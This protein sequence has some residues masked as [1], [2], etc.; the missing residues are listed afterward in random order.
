MMENDDEDDN[1][2]DWDPDQG[3]ETDD[4]ANE[5]NNDRNNA[6]EHDFSQSYYGFFSD[7]AADDGDG[8]DTQTSN[9]SH[10]KKSSSFAA[11]SSS[12]LFDQYIDDF[13]N[14]SNEY[15]NGHIDSDALQ[16]FYNEASLQR[17]PLS[18]SP[19][20]VF[21]QLSQTS[22]FSAAELSRIEESLLSQSSHHDVEVERQRQKAERKRKR[23]L[24]SIVGRKKR[25]KYHLSEQQI[26]RRLDYCR[27]K[28]EKT[29]D[30][31]KEEDVGGSMEY[32]IRQKLNEPGEQQRLRKI[33]KEREVQRIKRE[34]D[35]QDEL[36]RKR[37][38][39]MWT[40]SSEVDNR[41]NTL[42]E[43][44]DHKEAQA[45]K[46]S[47]LIASKPQPNWNFLDEGYVT[48]PR[49]QAEELP[50]YIFNMLNGSDGQAEGEE[51]T[52]SKT[53]YR[54]RLWLEDITSDA[55]TDK[56]KTA[57][58][59]ASLTKAH[60]KE[61]REEY[62]S[63][64]G[65]TRNLFTA[66]SR[67]FPLYLSELNPKIDL[68]TFS[69][70][71]SCGQ[72][73]MALL[74]G[75]NAKNIWA[76]LVAGGVTFKMLEKYYDNAQDEK[77]NT[78]NE[79][80]PTSDV[81]HSSGSSDS[82]DAFDIYGS[83]DN[84]S[85]YNS[86]TTFGCTSVIGMADSTN[87]DEGVGKGLK[88]NPV[89]RLMSLVHT[90]PKITHR[91][92]FYVKI[93]T[94]LG[95]LR[96]WWEQEFRD[97]LD[98]P[99]TNLGNTKKPSSAELWA[100]KSLFG[101]DGNITPGPFWCS[102]P[103]MMTSPKKLYKRIQAIRLK[104]IPRLRQL[105]RETKRSALPA[106]RNS[107]LPKENQD[108]E[109]AKAMMA[110][111]TNRVEGDTLAK[112]SVNTEVNGTPENT[113][114]K[115]ERCNTDP[116]ERTETS[117][118][119]ED[120]MKSLTCSLLDTI[121]P[122][123]DPGGFDKYAK[124][125][126]EA[127]IDV[128]NIV[129]S[130][131]SF[132][133]ELTESSERIHHLKQIVPLS[134]YQ[135]AEIRLAH[136]NACMWNNTID[137]YL[138]LAET[139]SRPLDL[140]IYKREEKL[141]QCAPLA[142]SVMARQAYI[143]NSGGVLHKRNQRRRLRSWQGNTKE[144]EDCYE[145]GDYYE[146][147][148]FANESLEQKELRAIQISAKDITI[149]GKEYSSIE[150]LSIFTNIHLTTGIAMLAEHLTPLRAEVV[151]RTCSADNTECRTPFDLVRKVLSD[152]DVSNELISSPLDRK[153]RWNARGKVIDDIIVESW[154]NAALLFRQCIEGEP[155]NVDHWT[156]YVATL[157]GIVCVSSGLSVSIF[158]QGSVSVSVKSEVS[159]TESKPKRHQLQFY[160]R[161]RTRASRAMKDFIQITE[162][163]DCPMFHMALSSMLEWTQAIALMHRPT[164]T[165]DTFGLEVTR[166]H[167]FHTYKWA[168]KDCCDDAIARV[169]SLYEKDHIPLN[170]LLD[171]LARA[172]ES[173]PCN[174]VHWYRLVH[175]L[176]A[177]TTVPVVKVCSPQGN[178]GETWCQKY[179]SEWEGN[180]FHSPPHSTLM[181]KPDF[182]TMVLD[183][184]DLDFF[185]TNSKCVDSRSKNSQFPKGGPF[186]SS[187]QCCLDWIWTS[188]YDDSVQES[189]SSSLV[190][191]TRL[192]TYVSKV[193]QTTS[194]F[195]DQNLSLKNIQEQLCNDPTCEAICL[196]VFVAHHMFGDC[197][198]VCNSIWWLAV[199]QWKA[200]LK[201]CAPNGY[202]IGLHWL[203]LQGLD[204]RQY[205][206]KKHTQ[207]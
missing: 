119:S 103:A 98:T 121:K 37:H 181:A 95:A 58:I 39:S 30:V 155:H 84:R 177:T 60:R 83:S 56:K 47:P 114:L 8:E 27:F 102:D 149:R 128:T 112:D 94:E 143:A 183:A 76:R 15:T 57:S 25:K 205:I 190:D 99:E 123:R 33:A 107:P 199:K 24:W 63:L 122:K 144:E 106:E 38:D 174:T 187:L 175:F 138:S 32:F 189:L 145:S 101:V 147:N 61:E 184:I 172:V 194:D 125:M 67:S 162:T 91:S 70:V 105:T 150:S 65:N 59:T 148:S 167:A 158:D 69:N 53:R 49:N 23:E 195:L 6:D 186:T 182:V 96:Q 127:N 133:D 85:K 176:G 19:R 170:Y 179:K 165:H 97:W 68:R 163:E 130:L 51:I 111:K 153:A 129:I 14:D 108:L 206:E 31:S 75:K 44:S 142:Q 198:F 157:L 77:S 113:A 86:Q 154:E 48:M 104:I 34:R 43:G 201:S 9:D 109:N 188:S 115:E 168:Y 29:I 110:I 131:S 17:T 40:M 146:D 71:K 4:I 202:I 192:P 72:D 50:Y 55:S 93:S 3:S 41:R 100:L 191:T 90:L 26:K 180:F 116:D 169:Q 137:E 62:I 207:K 7:D 160:D 64:D 82:F 120:R 73:G 2:D 185:A 28:Y 135:Q 132:L 22:N 193:T 13:D 156:W 203:H 80:E 78:T 166:L 161:R 45:Q 35:E 197:D 46:S 140:S 54:N 1:D 126:H 81:S 196:R 52:Q 141:P 118:N 89:H 21:S 36:A 11:S 151:S 12:M 42:D 88:N 139:Q 159:S 18:Q 79:E 66:R 10:G 178:N 92:R 136:E 164:S 5:S 134:L 16:S 171:I 74:H 204:I 200:K 20:P 117:T 173:E 124:V 152:L 87:E